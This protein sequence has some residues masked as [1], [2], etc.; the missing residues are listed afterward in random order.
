M[1][2]QKL[3]ALILLGLVCA[4]WQISGA[5]GSELAIGRRAPEIKAQSWLN[6]KP[7]SL[8]K[9]RGKVVV[10]EFWATWCPPCRHSIPHLSKLYDTQTHGLSMFCTRRAAR[11]GQGCV[12]RA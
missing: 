11:L 3:F 2:R 8:A 9:L 1:T 10:V 6:S 4:S 7:L 12:V 5:Y